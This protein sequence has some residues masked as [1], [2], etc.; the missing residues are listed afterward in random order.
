MAELQRQLAEIEEELSFARRYYNAVVER[1]NTSVQ[2]FPTLLVAG[3]FG[4]DRAAFF[5]ADDD[6]RSVPVVDV[7]R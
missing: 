2:S 1:L 3:P 6:A 7:D 5:R 4:F